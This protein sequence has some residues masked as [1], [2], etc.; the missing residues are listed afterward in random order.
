M[1]LSLKTKLK[2]N[3]G[4]TLLT[5]PT[6]K[7]FSQTPGS[8]TGGTTIQPSP[9]LNS[10]FSLSN[11]IGIGILSPRAWQEIKYCKPAS[12]QVFP[13]L[14][15]TYD[16]SCSNFF[17]PFSP[18]NIDDIAFPFVTPGGPEPNQILY[19]Y[20][21]LTGHHT[22]ILQPLYQPNKS[23]L[24][25]ARLQ[26]SSPGSFS[27]M[28]EYETKFIVQS[29]GSVGIN[30]AD[31]RAALDVRGSQGYN[32]PV[33]IFGARTLG[34]GT[35]VA[36]GLFKY[37]TQQMHFV[38]RLSDNGYN[39]ISIL[40]DQGMFFSDGMGQE[41]SNLNGSFVL[42]PWAQESEANLI[43]GMRMDKLGNVEFHGSVK[44]TRLLVEAKWW[45]DFVFDKNYKLID[46]LTLERFIQENKHLPD[47]PSEKEVLENGIDVTNMQAIQQQK[48]EELT[49]YIIQLKKELDLLKIEIDSLKN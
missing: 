14:I 38:S 42:A 47:V 24:L 44:A 35:T 41:G 17:P 16:N 3:L 19:P 20:S 32:R 5:S 30:L 49:L 27:G 25:W 26:N 31:P 15:L 1:I 28:E 18:G 13:G 7:T 29:D 45:S 40:N 21:F 10:T 36:N 2:F 22:N 9:T 43:G 11:S 8:W 4:I 46:L 34:T 6:I 12:G 37:Y 39:R 33:A 48:I 23:P